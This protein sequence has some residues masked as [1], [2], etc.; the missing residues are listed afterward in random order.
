M[1][2]HCESRNPA[3]MGLLLPQKQLG[4]HRINKWDTNL[5]NPQNSNI[6]QLNSFSTLVALKEGGGAQ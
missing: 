2:V 6:A 5:P 3:F 4:P 1:G